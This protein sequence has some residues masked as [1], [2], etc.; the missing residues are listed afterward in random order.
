MGELGFLGVERFL[1]VQAPNGADEHGRHAKPRAR[2]REDVSRHRDRPIVRHGRAEDG[3]E[4]EEYRQSRDA[5]PLLDV[6][7][8]GVK[9]FGVSACDES[10]MTC[11]PNALA[12]TVFHVSP[13]QRCRQ[14]AKIGKL[15]KLE[16]MARK[17]TRLEAARRIA[18]VD[19]M[20]GKAM[21]GGIHAGRRLWLISSFSDRNVGRL[22]S[23]GEKTRDLTLMNKK[24]RKT[25]Q[26]WTQDP[27]PATIAS[28]LSHAIQANAESKPRRKSATPL[29]W[30]AVERT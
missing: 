4:D 3:P 1:S 5:R 24:K 11:G 22:L 25:A 10:G 6:V 26:P 28:S 9:G 7:D 16:P 17:T 30:S 13:T 8:L 2:R 20:I 29:N 12:L 18:I 19:Q 15:T 14:K 21:G 27:D 23:S